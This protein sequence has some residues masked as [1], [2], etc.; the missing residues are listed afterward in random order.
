M[1]GYEG[2]TQTIRIVVRFREKPIPTIDSYIHIKEKGS[3]KGFS[4]EQ[5]HFGN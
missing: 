4:Y 3:T 1:T 2:Q 5:A